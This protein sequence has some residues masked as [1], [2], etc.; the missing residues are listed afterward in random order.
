[1]RLGNAQGNN[2]LQPASPT[3]RF[4]STMTLSNSL[5]DI[6]TVK[7]NCGDWWMQVGPCSSAQ[8]DCLTPSI[9]STESVAAQSPHL[10]PPRF[11]GGTECL[12]QIRNKRILSF[13]DGHPWLHTYEVVSTTTCYLCCQRRR[14]R[15]RLDRVKQPGLLKF[16]VLKWPIINT[17][18]GAEAVF[19]WKTTQRWYR[20]A[21]PAPPLGHMP[22]HTGRTERL[23]ICYKSEAKFDLPGNSQRLMVRKREITQRKS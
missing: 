19:F 17:S 3:P 15:G 4:P 2:R 6:P 21:E 11:M 23:K 9:W 18:D 8:Q 16:K 10:V 7:V 1:M 22:I 5:K 13:W 12:L 14:K 20:P